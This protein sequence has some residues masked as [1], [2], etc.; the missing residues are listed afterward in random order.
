MGAAALLDSLF[1]LDLTYVVL[2]RIDDNQT[3]TSTRATGGYDLPVL[4]RGKTDHKKSGEKNSF[5]SAFF[6]C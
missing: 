1:F 6:F 3:R 4:T 5:V 2:Y